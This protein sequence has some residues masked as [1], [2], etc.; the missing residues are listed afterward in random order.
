M[1]T[2]RGAT[3]RR[4]VCSLLHSDTRAALTS[5]PGQLMGIWT[6]DLPEDS[7]EAKLPFHGASALLL[8]ADWLE[9]PSSMQTRDT[10]AADKWPDPKMAP[11]FKPVINEYLHA[12]ARLADR[13]VVLS[14]LPKQTGCSLNLPVCAGWSGWS[15]CLW[16]CR[17]HTSISTCRRAASSRCPGALLCSSDRLRA[18]QDAFREVVC[19]RYTPEPSNEAEGVLG[20]GAHSD[21][22]FGTLLIG[23][24][25]PGLQIRYKGAPGAVCL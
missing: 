6:P 10:V 15:P 23:D 3:P 18:W 1:M 9:M 8:W 4:F 21:W 16:T 12:L 20:C 5:A 2:R 7:E 25:S 14:L 11:N 13:R 24:G 22:G 17:R 19:I